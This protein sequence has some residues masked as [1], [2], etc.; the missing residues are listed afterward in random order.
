MQCM[1]K[2]NFQVR[3]RN[4]CRRK[5]AVSIPELSSR[6]SALA[7]LYCRLCPV[8]FYNICPHYH[9]KGTIFRKLY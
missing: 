2:S 1:H 8:W 9:I 4:L 3:P 7:V 5:K 6:Q